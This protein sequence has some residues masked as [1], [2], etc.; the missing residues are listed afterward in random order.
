MNMAFISALL[1]KTTNSINWEQTGTIIAAVVAIFSIITYYT[2]RRDNRQDQ[3]DKALRDDFTNAINEMRTD[4]T[5]SIDHLA[6]VLNAKLETKETVARLSER[7]RALEV[8]DEV[9]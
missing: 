1:V 8:R 9:K 4:L 7:V 5:G 3:R 2:G 6:E